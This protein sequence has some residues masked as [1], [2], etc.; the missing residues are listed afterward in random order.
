MKKIATVLA[1]TSLAVISASASAWG[2][3]DSNLGN[4]ER[5]NP[6][7]GYGAHRYA[8]Y[9]YAPYGYGVPAMPV[10][11]AVELTEEQKQAIA[12][13]QAR[14]IEFMQNAQKQAAEYYAN[15]RSPM[16]DMQKAMM[17]EHE[18]RIKEMDARRE[19]SMKAYQARVEEANKAYEA[20]RKEREQQAGKSYEERR[21]EREEAYKARL[22]RYHNKPARDTGA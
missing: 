21:K 1:A 9:P 5:N 6:Y 18:A 20:R 22:E 13:Q 8:P 19:A 15:A 14:E 17:E 11:P 3:G 16:L 10:A 2:W 12:E 7:Y 4:D